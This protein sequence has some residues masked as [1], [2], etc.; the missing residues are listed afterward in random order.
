MKD[1][2]L[3]NLN[4]LANS[5]SFL[6]GSV[7]RY[8]S[9]MP[10]EPRTENIVI[11]AECTDKLA[12]IRTQIW[13]RKPELNLCNIDIARHNHPNCVIYD[14]DNPPPPNF[15]DSVLLREAIEFFSGL[16]NVH[17]KFVKEY[18]ETVIEQL[19]QRGNET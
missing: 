11:M 1:D 18:S 3:N 9:Q 4:D 16:K 19:I 2:E 10:F 5:C 12:N 7:T 17:N 15:E 14:E 8:I 6:I 13:D